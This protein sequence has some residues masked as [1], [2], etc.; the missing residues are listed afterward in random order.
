MFIGIDVSKQTLD[1]ARLTPGETLAQRRFANDAPGWAAIVRDLCARPLLQARQAAGLPVVLVNPAHLKAF[2]LASGKR[3][4]TARGDAGLLAHFALLYQP[5][6]R[7][8]RPAPEPQ[9]ALRALLDYRDTLVERPSAVQNQLTAAGW[10]AAAP[11]GLLALLAQ[12]RAQLAGLLRQV[13]AQ[14][15]ALLGQLVEAKVVQQSC[16]VGRW[17]AAAVLA[18]VPVALWGQAK[19][20]AGYAGIHPEQR[21]SGSSV[22]TSTLSRKGPP[23]LRK[24]LYMAAWVAVRHNERLRAYYQRLLGRG[25]AKQAALVAVAH[26]LLRH[27]MGT[28]KAYYATGQQP[29]FNGAT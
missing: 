27:M 18:Y 9:R 26:K 6:L 14:L 8:Y 29:T 23:R 25:K 28:L 13:A 21:C 19:A 4:K 5:Q 7:A 20:A 15:R 24:H 1:V 12:E 16:G 3:N 2:R 11:P 22:H 10:A 17:T